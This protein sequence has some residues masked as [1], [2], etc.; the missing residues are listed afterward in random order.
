MKKLYILFFVFT[1]IFSYSQNFRIPYRV[2]DLWGFADKTGKIIV[3][4]KYDSVSIEN[5]NFRWFVYKKHKIGVIDS[6]GDE[7]LLPEYDSIQRKPLHSKD[8]DFY[9][10]KESKKGY[11][12]INGKI[13]FSC[14]YNNIV[15]C[16]EMLIGKISNFFTQ[17]EKGNLWELK[18][19]KNTTLMNNIQEF[20]S[21]YNG[22]YKIKIDNK[23][24]FYNVTLKK[25]I[26]NPD[27]DQ[28]EYLDY[29]DFYKKKKEYSDYKYFAKKGQTYFLLTEDFKVSEF[30][31]EFS[32]FFEYIKTSGDVYSVFTG[33]DESEIKS[34][35]KPNT[36]LSKVYNFSYYYKNDPRY[37]KI[38]ENKNKFGVQVS[39][40][41]DIKNT[42]TEFDEIQLINN[43]GSYGN[44]VAFVRK[45][46]KWG[47]FNLKDFALISN[48]SYQEIIL[49]KKRNIIFIKD[50]NKIGLY[51]INDDRSDFKSQLIAPA[52]DKFVTLN[53]ARSLDYE[54]KSFNVYFLSKNG[55]LC[56]VGINGVE[57]YQD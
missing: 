41:Y 16:D 25:W 37:L 50:K 51:E 44:S 21:L 40:G 7:K 33:S 32:D 18:D 19:Y 30:K 15:A 36:E 53:Y 55:K 49:S 3:T 10:L 5:D 17:K 46:I 1:I 26:F 35:T 8:N 54:Y 43:G 42:P 12:D 47:I 28:I 22:N 2:K 27:Y 34:L 38:T 56:P 48:I 14:H 4:P 52:Y 20:K 24:G 57:F 45:K 29:K 6:L 23:W 39:Y 9:L 11:A 31:N 13:I